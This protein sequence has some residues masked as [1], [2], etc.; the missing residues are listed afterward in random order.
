MN[1][2]E[3]SPSKEN[4]KQL[5]DHFNNRKFNEVTTIGGEILRDF[6]NDAFVMNMVGLANFNIGKKTDALNWLKKAYEKAQET[7]KRQAI[8]R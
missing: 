1:N 3:T 2:T 7:L 8:W 4:L 5:V 6:P